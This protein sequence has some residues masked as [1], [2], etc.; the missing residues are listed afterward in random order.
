MEFDDQQ[1]IEFI[2]AHIPAETAARYDQDMIQYFIDT[3]FDFC[4]DSGLLDIDLDEDPDEAEARE[5]SQIIDGLTKL[6]SHD[7]FY[8]FRP[9]DI[10]L[11]VDAEAEYEQTLD[12]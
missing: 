6:L 12:L 1:A 10:A 11:L 8:N 9:E 2:L 4:E 5:R 7:K 3:L